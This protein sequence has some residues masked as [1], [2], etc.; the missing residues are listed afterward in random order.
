MPTSVLW[1]V[2]KERLSSVEHVADKAAN[3]LGY[4]AIEDVGGA[5]AGAFTK[6]L[7]FYRLAQSEG[8][9]SAAVG[10]A[11]EGQAKGG[12]AFRGDRR[13][14]LG[15][16]TVK[17]PCSGPEDPMDALTCNRLCAVIEWVTGQ[18]LGGEI[19]GFWFAVGAGR[20]DSFSEGLDGCGDEAADGA[21]E[22]AFKENGGVFLLFE[23]HAQV[24]CAGRA[25]C[26]LGV[27]RSQGCF[28]RLRITSSLPGHLIRCRRAQG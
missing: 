26:C 22:Q 9:Q 15:K 25:G 17:R 28:R 18:F 3:F 8:R 16:N 11:H 7:I 4:N 23:G 13:V 14:E 2:S 19:R 12:A 5:F 21:C 6:S 24:G 27:A 1:R 10:H 20:V